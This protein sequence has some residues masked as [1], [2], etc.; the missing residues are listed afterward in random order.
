MALNKA[1][2]IDLEDLD[3]ESVLE[4]SETRTL[5]EV[6][7]LIAQQAKVN[8]VSPVAFL[9]GRCSANR[10]FQAIRVA[11]V[12][13]IAGS[14]YALWFLAA[15]ALMFDAGYI[16]LQLFRGR[17]EIPEIATLGELAERIGG[18]GEA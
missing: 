1:W 7:E 5:R 16:P 6:C 11:I 14:L 18:F 4:P 9:G 10:A 12:A 2:S 3:W 15:F 8:K 17:L 13:G